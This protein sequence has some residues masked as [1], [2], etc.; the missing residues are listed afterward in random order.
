[1]SRL[2]VEGSS[3]LHSQFNEYVANNADRLDISGRPPMPNH[4]DLAL[5]M[6]RQWQ[7]VS[8]NSSEKPSASVCRSDDL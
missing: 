8:S 5:S 1:M 4:V 2:S 6:E 3:S 7:E